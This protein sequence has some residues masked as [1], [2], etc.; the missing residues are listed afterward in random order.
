MINVPTYLFLDDFEHRSLWKE[1]EPVWTALSAIG[2]Y[3]AR[4][5]FRIEIEIPNGVFLQNPSLISIGKG[6]VI[7][8]GVMII[9][10]C[11][12]G[13]NCVIRHGAYLREEVILGDGCHIGHSS[14]LKHSILLNHAAATHFVYAGDSILGNSVNLG[15]GVKCANLRLDRREVSIPVDGKRWKT[16][17]KKFG[18]VVGDLTQIG[19]NCVLNPG[20]LIGKESFSHPL[21]NLKG[22]IPSRSQVDAKGVRPIEQNI[23][24]KLLWQSSSTAPK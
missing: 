4:H 5:H 7:E 23:L 21:M 17:L 18:A 10:P 12:I 8:P 20:T 24:E 14:E 11:I 16:G 1:G 6:T 2:D 9:G 13:K 3:M 22:C 15:A 19:C